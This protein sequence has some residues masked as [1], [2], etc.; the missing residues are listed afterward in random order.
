MIAFEP[1]EPDPAHYRERATVLM[2]LAM[3]EPDILIANALREV[4]A[5]M[6][7]KLDQLDDAYALSRQSRRH[8]APGHRGDGRAVDGRDLSAFRARRRS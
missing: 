1:F 4:A 2:Q 8:S 5:W 3:S 7:A 6:L